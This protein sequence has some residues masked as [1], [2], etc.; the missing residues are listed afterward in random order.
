MARVLV[1]DDEEIIRQMLRRGLQQAGH[2][3][4]EAADGNEALRLQRE[5]PADVIVTDIIMP[6]K[7]GMELILLLKREFP[8][9]KIIAI[10]G[11]GR[12]GAQGYLELAQRFGAA[13]VFGKPFELAEL[14]DAIDELLTRPPD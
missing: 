13:R 5:N 1:V 10:S 2:D 12:I 6:E 11:G 8:D 3:V 7:E 9:T 14:T 4:D